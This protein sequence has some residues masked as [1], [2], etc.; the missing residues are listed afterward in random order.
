MQHSTGGHHPLV[1]ARLT[2]SCSLPH[3]SCHF[4]PS[5]WP[6]FTQQ[7]LIL[8]CY[9]WECKLD[10]SVAPTHFLLRQQRAF[11]CVVA[12]TPTHL[13][14]T[15]TLF[16]YQW[17]SRHFCNHP[18]PV[19]LS[20]SI[21]LTWLPSP[22]S[23]CPFPCPPESLHQVQALVKA[24]FTNVYKQSLDYFRFVHTHKI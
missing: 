1:R 3:N 24:M 13:Y 7:L 10:A 17:K 19:S 20:V 8:F 15:V 18:Y 14:P 4:S 16:R 9:Q 23:P 22:S 5:P 11:F 6:M 12:L 21:F 2:H